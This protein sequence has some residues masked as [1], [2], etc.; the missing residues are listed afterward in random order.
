MAGPRTHRSFCHNPPP[1]DENELAGG[2]T[3]AFTKGS[4]TSTPSPPVSR[5]QT[6]A[7][8]LAPTSAP[9]RGMYTDTD[10]QR[11]TKLALELFI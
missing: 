5:A 10:L 4:N 11:A 6:P 3:G 2:P 7:D 8:A 9:L 1:G